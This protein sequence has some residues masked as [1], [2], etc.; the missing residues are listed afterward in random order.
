[1][2][3]GKQPMIGDRQTAWH[4]HLMKTYRSNNISLSEAMKLASS[5]YRGKQDKRQVDSKY[6]GKRVTDLL[7][8]VTENIEDQ[9]MTAAKKSAETAISIMNETHEKIEQMFPEEAFKL[10]QAIK[11]LQV[12]T[13]PNTEFDQIKDVLERL[14]RLGTDNAPLTTV[15]GR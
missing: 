10:F 8:N 14:R 3:I 1:M 11:F 9:M 2:V 7:T 5:T 4:M 12:I 6:R 13:D 15:S